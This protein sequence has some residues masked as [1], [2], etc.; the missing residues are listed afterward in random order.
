MASFPDSDRELVL[1]ELREVDRRNLEA[2]STLADMASRNAAALA[3]LVPR[4]EALHRDF[5]EHVAEEMLAHAKQE[6]ANERVAEQLAALSVQLGPL[7]RPDGGR[8]AG[9]WAG[10]FVGGLVA[11]LVSV[12][13]TILGALK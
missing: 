1:R 4:F 7:S 9:A 3:V 12:G 8:K 2:H 13:P 5:A 10:A 6:A 11:G